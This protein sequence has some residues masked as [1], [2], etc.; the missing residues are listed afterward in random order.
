MNEPVD[1]NE[2][3]GKYEIEKYK[4]M[5]K[6]PGSLCLHKIFYNCIELNVMKIYTLYTLNIT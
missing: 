5:N 6:I 1:D 3:E 2:W 4:Y